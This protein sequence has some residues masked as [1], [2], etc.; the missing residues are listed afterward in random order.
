MGGGGTMLRGSCCMG[1]LLR[2]TVC[3]PRWRPS[4]CG[5]FRPRA[6]GVLLPVG[7]QGLGVALGLSVS[8]KI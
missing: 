2:A 6:L 7:S 8:L 1:H 4:F 5:C 3:C